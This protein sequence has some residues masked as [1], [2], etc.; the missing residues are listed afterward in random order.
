MES[1]SRRAGSGGRWAGNG[2][3]GGWDRGDGIR[4]GESGKIGRIIDR[5]ETC[6]FVWFILTH[7]ARSVWRRSDF[8]LIIFICSAYRPP[9]E[10]S[11]CIDAR[12]KKNSQ[13]HRLQG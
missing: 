7:Y 4:G 3:R 1:G 11:D 10:S 9:S 5:R 8:S 2:G 12:L 13:L 6:I